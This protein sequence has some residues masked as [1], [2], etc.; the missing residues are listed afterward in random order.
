[1]ACAT[2]DMCV[3]G[4]FIQKLSWDL[5]INSSS[6]LCMHSQTRLCCGNPP[7]V[8]DLICPSVIER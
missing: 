6:K 4:K 8:S 2:H 3:L 7:V 5:K 1:M